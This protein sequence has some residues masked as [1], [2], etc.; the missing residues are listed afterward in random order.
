M[1]LP[2]IQIQSTPARLDIR[3]EQGQYNIRQRM[4]DMNV[5]TTAAV[6]DIQTEQPIV[7]IDQSKTWDALTGGKSLI[8]FNRIYNQSGQF[9]QQAI[10]NTVR[11]YNQI[12]DLTN[13]TN[14]IPELAL[15]SI[16]RNSP[17][18]KYFGDASP[19]NVSFEAQLTTPKITVTPGT[20]DISITPNKPEVEYRRGKV[21]ISMAQYASVQVTAP[22][23]N[24]TR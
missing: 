8:F 1:R 15:Q 9:V 18:L 20:V 12:G 21:N 4:A 5:R 13:E 6:I 16:A 23:I 7:I 2:Q 19:L 22:Q 3:S 10:E 11:E 17:P 24:L 14:P